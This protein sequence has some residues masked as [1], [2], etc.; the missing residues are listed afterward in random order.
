M[1][2]DFQINLEQE[3]MSQPRCF[4]VFHMNAAAPIPGRYKRLSD[5]WKKAEIL[6]ACAGTLSA[7]TRIS[8]KTWV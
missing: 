7:T 2:R 6:H 4:V 3:E 1:T 8:S 5:A